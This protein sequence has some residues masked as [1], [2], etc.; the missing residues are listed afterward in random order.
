MASFQ[1]NFYAHVA[2]Q[3]E[4]DLY[5]V[6]TD[7]GEWAGTISDSDEVNTEFASGE[8]VSITDIGSVIFVGVVSIDTEAYFLTT[9]PMENRFY[10]FGEVANPNSL[11]LSGYMFN[12]DDVSEG[13]FT[14]CF[15]AGT[16]IAT[17]SGEVAVESLKTGDHVLTAEGRT[18][19]VRWLAR[20]TVHKLFT[21]ELRFRPVRL[22]AGALGDHV[23]HADLVLTADHGLLLDGLVIQ[24]GALVNGTTIVRVPMEDLPATVTY[25]HVDTGGHEA[26]LAA[27]VPA[28]TFVDNVTRRRFDNY[29]EYVAL[30]GAGGPTTTE[31]D[32]PRV[33]SARQLPQAIRRQ[34]AQRAEEIAGTACN[35]A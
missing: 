30:Y 32:L 35:A 20:Q 22:A 9:A 34:L 4:S 12:S 10:L 7:G 29:F 25:Y 6:V 13:T 8:T 2:Y 14:V 33:K 11:T 18:V 19:P 27:G 23:P 26:I 15:A 24:A 21:P 17:P 31:I 3:P 5:Q 1:F 28:E 16:L